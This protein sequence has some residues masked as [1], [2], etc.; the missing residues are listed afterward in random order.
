[1]SVQVSWS[2]PESQSEAILGYRITLMEY[3]GQS[4]LQM[5]NV[6]ASTFIT[7]F[8]N[9]LGKKYVQR[10][11]FLQCACSVT[12]GNL[13]VDHCIDFALSWSK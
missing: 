10:F 11:V 12:Y 9:G 8:D 5:K 7:L 13:A 3:D 2:E 4:E 6:N 1:M